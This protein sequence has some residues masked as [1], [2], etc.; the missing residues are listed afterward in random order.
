MQIGYQ[1]SFPVLFCFFFCSTC[2][3]CLHKRRFGKCSIDYRRW[4]HCFIMLVKKML[5][6]M[7]EIHSSNP[8]TTHC[9][10]Y[11]TD[12]HFVLNFSNIT[13]FLV[14]QI[15]EWFYSNT[16]LLSSIYME[17]INWCRSVESSIYSYLLWWKILTVF[18]RKYQP[19]RLT[20]SLELSIS[21]F[22]DSTILFTK[23]LALYSPTIQC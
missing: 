8:V 20:T 4:W 1:L 7:L 18:V 13:A 5:D 17:L 19:I 11:S 14:I 12:I 15:W 6:Q 22:W 16:A 21:I 10:L 9:E 3:C 2:Q 23:L